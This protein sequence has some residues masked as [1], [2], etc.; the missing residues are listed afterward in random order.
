[1]VEITRGSILNDAK[2]ELGI[3]ELA[4]PKNAQVV[5]LVYPIQK[6]YSDIV[7]SV[8]TNAS[9]GATLLTTP[10]DK[11]F[12]LTALSI[13]YVKDAAS[14]NVL[15]SLTCYTGGGFRYLVTLQNPTLTASSRELTLS[16]PYPIKV[17]RGTIIS[18]NGTFT[19]G[20]I[21]KYGMISGFILE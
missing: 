16:F 5:S 13:S 1:M 8:S 11:D 20:T 7:R 14:D 10:S 9:A 21:L 2:N 17:D 4:M 12:Y 3:Q 15:V 6:K 19:V 18:V